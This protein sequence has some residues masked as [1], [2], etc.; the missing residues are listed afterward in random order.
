PRAPARADE[1]RGRAA[2]TPAPACLQSRPFFAARSLAMYCA[3]DFGTSN[4]AVAIPDG[5]GGMRLVT[6]EDGHATMPTAVFH[7]ADG[8]PPAVGRAAI[9]AYV[10]GLD[11]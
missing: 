6:L 5:A 3:I 11:G 1:R 10:D 9:A 2:R 8:A 4:S 7:F